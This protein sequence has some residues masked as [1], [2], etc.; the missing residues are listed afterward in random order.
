MNEP[1]TLPSLIHCVVAS[2]PEVEAQKDISIWETVVTI[3]A[4]KG[5][6]YCLPVLREMLLPAAITFE[7]QKQRLL[8]QLEA[9]A[10]EHELD[11]PKA[12]KAA[13]GIVKHISKRNLKSIVDALSAKQEDPC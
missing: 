11:Y 9:Y 1:Q 13:Q 2:Q 8:K 7:L 12:K 5:L 3:I 10:L 4:W 6:G